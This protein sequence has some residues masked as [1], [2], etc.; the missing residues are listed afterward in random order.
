MFGKYNIEFNNGDQKLTLKYTPAQFDVI[1]DGDIPFEKFEEIFKEHIEPLYG[2]GCELIPLA[3][4]FN[5]KDKLIPLTLFIKEQTKEFFKNNSNLTAD[6]VLE[7]YENFNHDADAAINSL[8]NDEKFLEQKL[9]QIREK[10]QNAQSFI[11]E[12]DNLNS[13]N[14]EEYKDSRVKVEVS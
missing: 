4:N 9:V 7:A 10:I 6:E 13:K 8:L 12:L 2:L 11:D 1:V 14:N 5:S 3:E